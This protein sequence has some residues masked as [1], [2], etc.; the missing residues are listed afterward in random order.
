MEYIS[1]CRPQGT[2]MDYKCN[3]EIRKLE[4]TG[5]NNKLYQKNGRSF[6]KNE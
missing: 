5:I 6:G 3:E 2:E 4:I 1:S